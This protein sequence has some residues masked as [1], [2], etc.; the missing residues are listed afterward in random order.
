MPYGPIQERQAIVTAA[1]QNRQDIRQGVPFAFQRPRLTAAQAGY[2]VNQ[3]GS[4]EAFIAA[5][6]QYAP[7]IRNPY[8]NSSYSGYAYGPRPRDGKWY[9]YGYSPR[10]RGMSIGDAQVASPYSSPMPVSP[11]LQY[12]PWP[13]VPSTWPGRSALPR[14]KPTTDVPQTKANDIHATSW[15]KGVMWLDGAR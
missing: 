9:E 12:S 10:T 2:Q 6:P 13:G 5:Y 4:M 7:P 14:T 8:Y 15:R 11:R 3:P 1:A